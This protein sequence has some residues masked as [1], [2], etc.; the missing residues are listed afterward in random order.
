LSASLRI[1]AKISRNCSRV[2]LGLEV[3]P[4]ISPPIG[5][6]LAVDTSGGDLGSLHI[7]VTERYAVVV[8]EIERAEIAL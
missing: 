1:A 5:E 3:R 2:S 8:P 7:R 6:A 4:D